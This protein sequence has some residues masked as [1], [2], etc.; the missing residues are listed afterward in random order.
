M[1]TLPQ[2]TTL[3]PSHRQGSQWNT[4]THRAIHVLSDGRGGQ[5]QATDDFKL[6]NECPS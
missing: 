2:S 4:Y 6:A 3:C 5:E 1:V